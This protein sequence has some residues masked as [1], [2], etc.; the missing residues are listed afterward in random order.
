MRI[1]PPPEPTDGKPAGPGTRATRS[2]AH[3]QKRHDNRNAERD[4]FGNVIKRPAANSHP[5]VG[6]A[7]AQMG[8]R[9]TGA[10]ARP[11]A[12]NPE[13][14]PQK[15]APD[16][17]KPVR[18]DA[19]LVSRGLAPSREKAKASIAAGFVYVDGSNEVKASTPVAPDAVVEVR[20]VA[21]RYVGRG[22]L[23]LEKALDVFG[24]D[25]NG[26]LCLDLGA[27]TGGFTD[28]LLQHGAARVVAVDVGHGQLDPSLRDD[29][30]VVSLEGVD[31][32]AATP[33]AL[34]E[35]TGIAETD[36]GLRFDVVVADLSFISL[37]H[38]LD[39]VRDLLSEGGLAVLLVKPQFEAGRENVGKRGVVKDAGV[40]REVVAQV[41]SQARACGL[42]PCGLDFSPIKGPE[43]NIEYLLL[44]ERAAACGD[45]AAPDAPIDVRAVV[46]AAR[47]ALG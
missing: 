33:Q 41:M 1:K 29:P 28:C 11:A 30:R 42:V 36:G 17:E 35:K 3:A 47:A 23:K 8:A 34:A 19:A 39:T 5:T 15:P 45:N 26:A 13:G 25:V 38:V 20:G 32:R 37:G 40:H 21:V 14:V 24:I 16:T 46:E 2:S 9:G 10:P 12:G 6:S 4:Q 7:L 27:S 43:G 22:G 31:A 44:V 18:L